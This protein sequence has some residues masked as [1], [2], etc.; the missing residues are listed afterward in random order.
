[1]PAVQRVTGRASVH[2]ARTVNEKTGSLGK[3]DREMREVEVAKETVRGGPPL[4]DASWADAITL[5]Y[6][7]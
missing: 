4:S 7:D 1:M 3:A 2:W 5:P 6:F